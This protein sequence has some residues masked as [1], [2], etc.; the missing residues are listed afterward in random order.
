MFGCHLAALYVDDGFLLVDGLFAL[1]WLSAGATYNAM[2][3]DKYG[4]IRS[5]KARRF[6][7][8]TDTDKLPTRLA[9]AFGTNFMVI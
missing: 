7:N 5:S 2:A 9:T 1:A 3:D 4:S 6:T 8:V